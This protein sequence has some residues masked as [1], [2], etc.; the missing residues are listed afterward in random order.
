[1]VGYGTE[2]G[3][4]YWTVKNSWGAKWGEEGYFR[5]IRGQNECNIT[6]IPY[7]SEI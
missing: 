7:Y 3:K 2:D 6:S 5:I 4:D 1:L